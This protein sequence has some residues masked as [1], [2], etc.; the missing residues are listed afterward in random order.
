V[1]DRYSFNSDFISHSDSV[2]M[3]PRT[4]SSRPVSPAPD[5]A[6]VEITTGVSSATRPAGGELSDV[7]PRRPREGSRVRPPQDVY[8]PV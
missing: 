1:L 4:R 8:D 3:P 6:P 7:Q 2:K 5:A